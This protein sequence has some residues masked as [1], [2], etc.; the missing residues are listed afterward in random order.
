MFTSAIRAFGDLFS[1]E[2]RSVLLKAL[3]LTIALFIAV[4]VIA[5]VLI[6]SFTHFS[7]PWADRLVE[8]GTGLALLVAFFFLMS[9]VT[10]AF[11]GLFLD[12]IAEK[13]E[14]RHYPWDPRGTP[15]PAGRAILMAI[16]FFVVVLL[17]NL[18]VLP[19]VFFGFGVLVLIAAN[20][21]LIGREY[22]EMVAMRH[23]P[24]E[25]ARTLRKENS[26]TVFIA[27]LLPAVMSV[28]PF[29][30]LVVPLF[31]TAY[32]THL[33]KSVRASSA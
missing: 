29:V 9:P 30:N 13:V 1:P 2:F 27:A 8:I 5:E 21:Y 6:A 23:M 26:P 12:R 24:V 15:L 33:F 32:F 10:A 22:F 3:G 14:E 11:A 16:Q 31:S 19:T 17:V 7:W 20:A 28:V 25:E 18:A 4:L